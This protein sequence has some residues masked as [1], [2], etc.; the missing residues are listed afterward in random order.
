MLCVPRTHDNHGHTAEN[1]L[2]VLVVY[3]T[4]HS[5]K[6]EVQGFVVH[7]VMVVI[8]ACIYGTRAASAIR[9]TVN[10]ASTYITNVLCSRSE[11]TV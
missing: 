10:K 3:T 7:G 5:A 2:F 9:S 8:P 1:S 6:M 11:I 4:L